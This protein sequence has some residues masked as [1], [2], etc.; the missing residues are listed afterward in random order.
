MLVG[1]VNR[2]ERGILSQKSTT[3]VKTF[4]IEKFNT[5]RFVRIVS[6]KMPYIANG[7]HQNPLSFLGRVG[8]HGI[9]TDDYMVFD[10]RS[11]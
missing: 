2:S 6:I 4:E 3:I 5:R 9:D 10:S 8:K 11:L 7:K 1:W